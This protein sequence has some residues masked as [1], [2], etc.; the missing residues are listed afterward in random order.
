MTRRCVVT[1]AGSDS[2]GGAGIQADLRTFSAFGVHGAS[3]ITAITAQNSRE[4]TDV[5]VLPAATVT[6][7]IDAV[8]SDLRPDAVKSGM[9]GNA[10]VVHA[11]ADAIEKWQPAVF[12]LD[13]VMVASSGASLLEDDAVDAVRDRLL[14]L[15]TIVTPN[16]PEA[17]ALINAFPR[18]LEDVQRIGWSFRKLGVKNILIKG[19][20][21]PGETVV[22]T[23]YDGEQFTEFI[24]ERIPGAEGHGTGCTLASALAAQLVLGA[25]LESACRTAVDF[26]YEALRLRYGVGSSLEVFLGIGNES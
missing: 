17:G 14:P 13:P 8:M 4:V 22:D 11:V 24:H 9:L 12:V 15:A 6:A 1:I 19:G 23:L 5:F 25:S 3:V 20:H 7:Q 18:G 10:E 21:L 26:V 2:G 16:W